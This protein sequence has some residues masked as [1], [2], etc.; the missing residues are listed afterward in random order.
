MDGTFVALL[1]LM[2][3]LTFRTLVPFMAF[4]AFLAVLPVLPVVPVVP[5]STAFRAGVDARVL[6]MLVPMR[7]SC[8]FAA[9]RLA[10]AFAPV[11]SFAGVSAFPGIAGIAGVTTLATFAFAGCARFTALALGLG[12]GGRLHGLASLLRLGWR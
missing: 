12:L 2:A 1:T 8:R 10:L 5:F 6:A 11:T 3:F 7:L 9:L 4:G